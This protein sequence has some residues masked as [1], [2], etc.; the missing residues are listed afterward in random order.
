MF[1]IV[2]VRVSPGLRLGSPVSPMLVSSLTLFAPLVTGAGGSPPSVIGILLYGSLV[3]STMASWS[4]VPVFFT[5]NVTSPAGA[6]AGDAVNVIGPPTPAVVAT[7][8][9]A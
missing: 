6:V 2:K 8:T 5:T 1:L 4:I 9:L 7:V 3:L